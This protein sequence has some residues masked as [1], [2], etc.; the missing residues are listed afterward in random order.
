[1]FRYLDRSVTEQCNIPST[2]AST[3]RIKSLKPKALG[4]KKSLVCLQ[5]VKRTLNCL[6]VVNSS[7]N[8]RRIDNKMI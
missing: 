7:L 8:E 5:H 4:R 2:W 3:D 1:M 6:M